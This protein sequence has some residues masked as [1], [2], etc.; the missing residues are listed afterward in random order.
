VADRESAALAEALS[1]GTCLKQEIVPATLSMFVDTFRRKARAV[2]KVKYLSRDDGM[3]LLNKTVYL[4][5]YIVFMT[6]GA[7]AGL[8]FMLLTRCTD[9]RC[10]IL[11][12]PVSAMIFGALLGLLL[13]SG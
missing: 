3:K 7:L 12:N 5:R 1:A 8:V 11:G 10:L 6:C 2:T 9:G 13:S 4:N